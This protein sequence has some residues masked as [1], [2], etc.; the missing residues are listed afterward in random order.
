MVFVF[1]LAIQN[2]DLPVLDWLHRE[3]QGRLP[4][5]TEPVE[6]YDPHVIYWLHDHGGRDLSVRLQ[7]HSS[8]KAGWEFIK[9]CI[10]HGDA[11]KVYLHSPTAAFDCAAEGD[12]EM[13]QQLLEYLPEL[14]TPDSMA[15]LVRK[16]NFDAAKWLYDNRPKLY[17]SDIVE[18]SPSGGIKR[19]LGL[20]DVRW[21]A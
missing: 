20:E 17:F 7:L 18:I 13:V 8:K 5:L 9:W 6:C 11:Y 3:T 21:I 14:C 2:S 1:E 15:L 10:E 19:Q 12:V 4:E 16:R